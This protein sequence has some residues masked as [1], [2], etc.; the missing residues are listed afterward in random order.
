MLASSAPAL[1]KP[2]GRTQPCPSTDS[3]SSVR[4]RPFDIPLL[5]LTAPIAAISPAPEPAL[6]VPAC[7]PDLA[8]RRTDMWTP[9]SHTPAVRAHITC[10]KAST[11][12]VFTAQALR[13]RHSLALRWEVGTEQWVNYCT[14][15]HLGQQQNQKLSISWKRRPNQLLSSHL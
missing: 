7:V 8:L 15:Q 3:S 12:V 13:P 9:V 4:L 1:P 6:P 11:W 10:P 5:T 14:A 2:M